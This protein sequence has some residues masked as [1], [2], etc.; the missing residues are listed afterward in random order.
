M[1]TPRRKSGA[2][3]AGIKSRVRRHMAHNVASVTS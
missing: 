3:D 1:I 2:A